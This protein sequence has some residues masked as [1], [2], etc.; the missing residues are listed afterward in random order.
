MGRCDREPSVSCTLLTFTKTSVVVAAQIGAMPDPVASA[1][2]PRSVRVTVTIRSAAAARRHKSAGSS[3]C[4]SDR[5]KS[6]ATNLLGPCRY[7]PEALAVKV[8]RPDRAGPI[9]EAASSQATTRRRCARHARWGADRWAAHR[10]HRRAGHPPAR[11]P[12]PRLLGRLGPGR[13]HHH[14]RTAAQPGLRLHHPHLQPVHRGAAVTRRRTVRRAGPTSW[15]LG[16]PAAT[17]SCDIVSC[18]ST[19]VVVCSPTRP[20]RPTGD[21]DG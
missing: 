14:G 20:A 15:K 16:H 17:D 10:R 3:S 9:T 7:D 12:P 2:S 11:V 6:P 1:T 18:G 21:R 19:A 4:A 13:S 8:D 5:E